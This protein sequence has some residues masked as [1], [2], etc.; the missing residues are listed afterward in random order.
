MFSQL[1]GWID[2]VPGQG[3][4]EYAMPCNYGINVFPY[5]D[6]IRIVPIHALC[7]T[8]QSSYPLPYALLDRAV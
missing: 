2:L 4:V 6:L 1:E 5:T 3:D 7:Y 8:A